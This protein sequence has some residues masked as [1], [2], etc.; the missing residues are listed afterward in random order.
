MDR[1]D[2]QIL[3]ALIQNPTQ[4]FLKIAQKIDISPSTV[5]ERYEKMRGKVFNDPFTIIDLSRIGYQGRALLMIK[6]SDK[7]D[8]K[9]IVEKVQK[10]PNVFLITETLGKFDLIVQVAF[11]DVKEI[12]MIVNKVRA[13]LGIK[14]VNIAINDQTDFPTNREYTTRIKLR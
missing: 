14:K 6:Y 13:L 12:K 5:K 10:I 11:R 2:K 9:I 7:S 4:P 3:G 1:I 8:Y